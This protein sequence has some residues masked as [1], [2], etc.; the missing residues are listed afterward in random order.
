MPPESTSPQSGTTPSEKLVGE[1]MGLCAQPED[2]ATTPLRDVTAEEVRS[3]VLA[4]GDKFIPIRACSICSR[5]IGYQMLGE[6][7]HLDTNCDCVSYTTPLVAKTWESLAEGV[8][9]QS[10]DRGKRMVAARYHIDLDQPLAM[11]E[12]PEIHRLMVLST[13]HIQREVN[14]VFGDGQYDETA[15]DAAMSAEEWTG[16]HVTSTDG[17]YLLRGWFNDDEI[18]VPQCLMDIIAYAKEHGCQ[19]VRLDQDGPTVKALPTYTW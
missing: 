9:I 6:V 14:S 7:P 3:A 8:N 19:Y 4:S 13:G 18:V 2:R 16:L 11:D 5:D 12:A 15:I 1:P 10:T 17:G